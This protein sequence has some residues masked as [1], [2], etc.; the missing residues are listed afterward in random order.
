MSG[1]RDGTKITPIYQVND[2]AS[3]LSNVEPV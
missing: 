1:T 2:R 3:A